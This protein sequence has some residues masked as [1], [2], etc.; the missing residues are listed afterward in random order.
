MVTSQIAKPRGEGIFV[1]IVLM[2]HNL[3][4]VNSSS[5]TV[6]GMTER[7]IPELCIYGKILLKVLKT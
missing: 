3:G 1:S 7:Y 5:S 6:R 4:N 2:S